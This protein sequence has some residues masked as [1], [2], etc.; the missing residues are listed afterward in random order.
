MK[1]FKFHPQTPETVKQAL[2]RLHENGHRVRIFLG[3]S[4]TGT[5]WMEEFEVI[6]TVGKSTGSHPIPLMIANSR[7]YGGGAISDHCIVK[8]IDITT[9]QT[10][11]EHPKYNNPAA[12]AVVGPVPMGD[13]VK[14]GYITEVTIDGEVHA[15]FKKPGAANRWIEFMQGT[16]FSK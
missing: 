5:A 1:E 8:I 7:S 4:Q 3:D 11:Y 12:R 16:R 10:L 14:M 6:G 13:L 15:R 2:T 9:R